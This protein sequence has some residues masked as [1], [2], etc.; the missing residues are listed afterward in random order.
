MLAS[1]NAERSQ[2][3]KIAL[4]ASCAPDVSLLLL[5][6]RLLDE[7][8]RRYRAFR[9]EATVSGWRQSKAV[10]EAQ[11]PMMHESQRAFLAINAPKTAT[12]MREYLAEPHFGELAAGVLAAQ[13]RAASDPARD[14]RFSG[15]VDFSRVEEKR[16]AYAANPVTTSAEAEAIFA[17]I[18][19]LISDGATDDQKKL[20]VALGVVAASLPH[21]QRDAMI[22]KLIQLTP[23]RARCKLL[24]NL[25]LS[26]AVIDCRLVTDGIAETLEAA[27]RESR[28]L[29]QSDGY[30]LREWL[31]LLPFTNCPAA[32]LEV[33]HGLPDAQRYPR[34][35]EEL[36][37]SLAETP[38]EGGED[39]LF[40]L[41]EEDPRFYQNR[42]WRTV[43]LKLGTATAARRI[44][45]LTVIGAFDAK[46]FDDSSWSRELAGLI[47]E[48]PEVRRHVYG[49]LKDG[50][51]SKHLAL[52][53]RAV[54]ECLDAEGLLLLVD[55]ENQQKL[56]MLGWHSIEQVVTQH[57]PIENRSG[58]YNIVSVPAIELRQRLLAKTTDGGASD[59]AARCLSVID[60]LR[61]KHGIPLSEPR[62]PD[63]ASGKPWPIMRPDPG[64]TTEG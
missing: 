33:V 59:A 3:A 42:H 43:V 54:S 62:H 26:G 63:L 35:L 44:M 29:T 12:L 5:L 23:R 27:K 47:A 55:L 28:L 51:T 37:G 58:W 40:T 20:A 13:W 25:I 2:L 15:G 56:S 52:L 6:K 64:A 46:S 30:E 1:G 48:F 50:T 14:Q 4:L 34:F 41:A 10:H 60:V 11:M 17:A 7:N 57:V 53:A 21:G 39:V 9:E 32:A 18:E 8:L 24:L 38:S 36:V 45:D 49:L 31:R 16:A 61:D 19:P 22:E